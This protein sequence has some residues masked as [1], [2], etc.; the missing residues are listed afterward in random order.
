MHTYVYTDREECIKSTIL[1]IIATILQK[2]F[3]LT[4]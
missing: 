4:Q 2:Y 1:T 3:S